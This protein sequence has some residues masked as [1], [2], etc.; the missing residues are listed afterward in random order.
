MKIIVF[1]FCIMINAHSIAQID[2]MYGQDCITQD[3]LVAALKLTGLSI[4]KFKV[5]INDNNKYY[6]LF[7]IQEYI[8]TAMIGEKELVY[9]TTPHS[10]FENHVKVQKDLDMLRIIIRKMNTDSSTLFFDTEIFGGKTTHRFRT[11]LNSSFTN[12]FDSRPF[13]LD[14]QKINGY[15]PLVMIGS[16]WK[17]G[18]VER[19]C[20]DNRLDADFSS[21]A[22]SFMP[23]YYLVGYHLLDKKR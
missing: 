11:V 13:K 23:T 14:S 10:S 17:D 4:N 8:G 16:F 12:N 19:F 21:E 18:N 5:N 3:D 6:L 20:M 1:I 9:I 7:T 15:H 22:F 2:T